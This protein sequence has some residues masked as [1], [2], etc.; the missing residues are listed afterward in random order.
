VNGRSS[1]PAPSTYAELV[2]HAAGL[3]D[4]TIARRIVGA[5]PVRPLT[6]FKRTTARWNRFDLL[7][8]PLPGLLVLGDAV[9]SLN[10]LFG[11]GLSLAAWEASE[12]RR[13]LD[14]WGRGDLDLGTA[15]AD[16]HRRV[17]ALVDQVWRLGAAVEGGVL[18][19]TADLDERRR[20][21]DAFVAELRADAGLH[22]RYVEVWHLLRPVSELR[23][24][25]LAT[26]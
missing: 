15:T 8:H 14:P 4:D 18:G 19:E 24:P 3:A 12:L 25:T 7:A 11:Q 1:D 6:R 21:A 16:A 23:A 26:A 17:G 22:R 2:A 13:T 9:A 10:P 5:R 20:R